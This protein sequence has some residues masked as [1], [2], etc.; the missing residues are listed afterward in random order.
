MELPE[1]ATTTGEEDEDA[2]VDIKARRP[3]A[4]ARQ[5]ALVLPPAL[6]P[7]YLSGLWAGE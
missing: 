2:L 4:V 1:V 3:I 6:S 7:I 5:R